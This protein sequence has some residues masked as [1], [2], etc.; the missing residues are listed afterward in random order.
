MRPSEQRNWLFI[1]CIAITALLLYLVSWNIAGAQSPEPTP[2]VQP[3]E[4]TATPT[5]TATATPQAT[6]TPTGIAI[7]PM[8]TPTNTQRPRPTFEM[9][10]ARSGSNA[11]MPVVRVP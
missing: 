2:T 3:F 6:A 11:H 5:G 10:P 9:T 1:I 7:S 4:P 8:P